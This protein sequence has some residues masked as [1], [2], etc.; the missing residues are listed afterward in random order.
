MILSKEET[1]AVNARIHEMI[2]EA[3]SL[4]QHKTFHFEGRNL[5]YLVCSCGKRWE[6]EV[7]YIKN[8]RYTY[9]KAVDKNL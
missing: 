1:E 2:I 3:L 7:N 6:R 9:F 8:T 4:C 5:A